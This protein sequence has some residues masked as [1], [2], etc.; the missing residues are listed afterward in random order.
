LFVFFIKY[1]ITIHIFIHI[2]SI[3]AIVSFWKVVIG[4]HIS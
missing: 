4:R 3:E 2:L 1:L